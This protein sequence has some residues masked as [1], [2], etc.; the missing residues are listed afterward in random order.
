MRRRFETR[1]LKEQDPLPFRVIEYTS[2][3]YALFMVTYLVAMAGG[4]ML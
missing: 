1:R 3:F 2:T 4:W